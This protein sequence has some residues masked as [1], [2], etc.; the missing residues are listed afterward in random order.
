MNASLK[1]LNDHELLAKFA[2]LRLDADVSEN[3]HR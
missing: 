2:A 1:D 3:N